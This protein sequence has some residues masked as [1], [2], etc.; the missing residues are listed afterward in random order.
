MRKF[1][2]LP[3]QSVENIRDSAFPDEFEMAANRLQKRWLEKHDKQ[4]PEG[5]HLRAL[6]EIRVRA[7]P[8][9][10]A[11]EVHI[12]FWFVKESDPVGF[13]AAWTLGP[14]T[15]SNCSTITSVFVSTRQLSVALRI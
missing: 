10:D 1:E 14:K 9:W 2:T 13:P 7:A 11:S 15:G 3:K 6:R 12:S 4:S 5:A 8:S